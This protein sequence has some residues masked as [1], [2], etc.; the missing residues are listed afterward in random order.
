MN[1]ADAFRLH[2]ELRPEKVALEY[3]G[4]TL[5]YADAWRGVSALANT[6]KSAG[7][8]T[9]DHVGLCLRDHPSHLLLHYSI[10]LLGAVIVP[11]DHRWSAREQA[12]ASA[13]F[14]VK[15][16]VLDRAEAAVQDCDCIEVD[17]WPESEA[18]LSPLPDRADSSLLISMSSGTTGKPKGALVTHR[19]LYERFVTQW[20]TLG[21]NTTDRFA[22]VTPLF[23]GAGRSFGMAF[24]AAGATIVL[25]PPPHKGAELADAINRSSATTTFLVPTAMR[26]LIER[27]DQRP[28]FPTLRRLLISGEA[29]Y[30]NEVD[31]FQSALSPNLIGYYASSEGGGVSVLQPDEFSRHGASVGQAAFG[32]EVD[33]VDE[34][35][36]RVASDVV[37]RLRYRGPGVTTQTLNEHGE[38]APVDPDGWFYPGDLASIDK[39]GF[40]TLR[41]R[42]KDVIIRGGVNIYP[43]EVEQALLEHSAIKEAAVLGIAD[44]VRGEEITAFVA[45]EAVLDS[46]TLTDWLKERLAPYKIPARFIVLDA[47]PK[48]ASGKTD[49]K[50]LRRQFAD[51]RD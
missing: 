1:I 30:P 31:E 7:V 14:D 9:G 32:V 37:G 51:E 24:L 17:V 13:A 8:T 5:N 26:R 33:C 3:R 15:L 41:G 4:R 20:V 36:E 23:F 45:S 46:A 22:L 34:A 10:A 50:A 6:L 25:A 47:L 19:Q 12:A 11:I 42:A 40:I 35:G 44:S 21:F 18:P 49:K 48:A 28:L 39:A 16:V 27:A 29:F 38:P 43:A 2:A